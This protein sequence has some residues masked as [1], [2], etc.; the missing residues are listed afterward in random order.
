[1]LF[2]QQGIES[3]ESQFSKEKKENILFKP[4]YD[5]SMGGGWEPC[6]Y[7]HPPAPLTT[8]LSLRWA[9]GMQHVILY[10]WPHRLVGR[11]TGVTGREDERRSVNNFLYFKELIGNSTF[12]WIWV[13]VSPRHPPPFFLLLAVWLYRGPPHANQD[14]SWAK[15]KFDESPELWQQGDLGSSPGSS[16]SLQNGFDGASWTSIFLSVN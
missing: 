5:I 15:W 6:T 4:M 2:R 7:T 14:L 8:E 3:Q 9:D 11:V 10:L 1:M 12:V 13:P 16:A